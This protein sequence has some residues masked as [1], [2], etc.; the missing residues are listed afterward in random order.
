MLGLPQAIASGIVSGLIAGNQA[1]K[2]GLSYGDAFMKGV[3]VG[4]VSSMVSQAGFELGTFAGGETGAYVGSAMAG[5]IM[6]VAQ[7]GDIGQAMLAATISIGIR[8]VSQPAFGSQGWFNQLLL[9]AGTNYIVGGVQSVMNGGSFHRGGLNSAAWGTASFV[10]V[11][12][13]NEDTTMGGGISGVTNEGEHTGMFTQVKDRN[14]K[15]AG[16]LTVDYR[17]KGFNSSGNFISDIINYFSG[18]GEIQFSYSP[19]MPVG[20][21]NVIILGGNTDKLADYLLASTN[22]TQEWLWDT[23]DVGEKTSTFY[24]PPQDVQESPYTYNVVHGNCNH[25]TKGGLDILFGRNKWLT[26]NAILVIFVPQFAGPTKLPNGRWTFGQ[27]A[28]LT[29]FEVIQSLRDSPFRS[30]M[31]YDEGMLFG[32]D[33]GSQ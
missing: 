11:S 29:G 26:R 13:L 4:V 27:E 5:A 6:T 22:K 20:K 18:P 28:G 21:G 25:F 17:F 16:F 2:A 8:A 31:M 33:I 7:G 10:L 9:S 30:K 15:N 32:D 1:D 19:Q 23:I 12:F 24:Y 3:L 14:G